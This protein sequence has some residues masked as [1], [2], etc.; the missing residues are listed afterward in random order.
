MSC[1]HEYIPSNIDGYEVCKLCKTYHSI[2]PQD[3]RSM[4]TN[5]YWAGKHSSIWEQVWNVDMEIR[6]GVCKNRFV[7]DRITSNR[8][9]ALEI[10]CAPGR[11]LYWLTYAARFKT[12]VGIDPGPPD[13][14]RAAGC[15]TGPLYTGL[16]PEITR[17]WLANSF[18]LIAATDVFEHTPFPEEFL[19]ECRRLLRPEGQ[20]LLMLPLSDELPSGSQMFAPEEHVFLHSRENIIGMLKTHGLINTQF[21]TWTI[22]HDLISSRKES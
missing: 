16:F 5:G 4:Y 7:L 15:F 6:N 18:D 14:I 2:S 10:G 22:G 12:I 8:E 20:L 17:D 1:G 11:L 13:D 9:S 21:S 3:P 19:A